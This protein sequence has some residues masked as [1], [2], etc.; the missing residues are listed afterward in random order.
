M[1]IVDESAPVNWQA[2]IQ[3]DY[4]PLGGSRHYIAAVRGQVLRK[5]NGKPRT[6]SS[7][8]AAEQ[9]AIAEARKQ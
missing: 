2:I 5:A 9:A 1:I 6:F 8:A 7:R 3:T 4:R